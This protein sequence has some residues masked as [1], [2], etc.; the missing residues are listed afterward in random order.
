[1]TD[2]IRALL[3]EMNVLEGEL[4]TALREQQSSMFFQI[5]GKRVAF[6]RSVRAEH[7]KLKSNLLHW[8]VTYRPQNLLTGPIIYGMAIPLAL[9]DLCIS[10]YQACCFPIYGIVKVD[11]ANYFIFD[12]HHLGYLNIVEKF[13][14]T[15]C[16]YGTGLIAYCTEIIARTE[17]YFCPIKHAR[18]MLGSH[19]RHSRF[20][21][22]G[23]AVDYEKKLEEYRVALGKTE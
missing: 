22:F 15:Y 9:V 12:R 14:C 11:R 2:K 8:L 10:F 1:M 5:D 18:K 21:E 23:D 19:Q 17:Q 13:H 16:A 20:L 7:R 4:A 6:E 3:A